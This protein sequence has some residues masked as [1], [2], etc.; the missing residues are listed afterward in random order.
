[1]LH[2]ISPER[3]VVNAPGTVPRSR[4]G[5]PRAGPLDHREGELY[6]TR[7][8]EGW[9]ENIHREE[10]VRRRGVYAVVD[11]EHTSRSW[12][13]RGETCSRTALHA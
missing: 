2:Q 10:N 13:G 5:R 4:A 6:Q 9:R 1:M 8:H 11:S 7:E 12:M 3:A